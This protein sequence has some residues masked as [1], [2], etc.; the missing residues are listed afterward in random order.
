MTFAATN[1]QRGPQR[2]AFRGACAPAVAVDKP[3][4]SFEDALCKGS[5]DWDLDFGGLAEWVA[6]MTR[7][8]DCPMLQACRAELDAAYPEW[9]TRMGLSS[10]RN[11][12]GVIWAGWAFSD[13]GTVLTEKGLRRTASERRARRT[14][15]AS[16]LREAS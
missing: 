4:Q 13:A 6:A 10:D 9:W 5:S 7:C 3:R 12:A 2:S 8:H 11:P 14:A 1:W 15:E 16:D